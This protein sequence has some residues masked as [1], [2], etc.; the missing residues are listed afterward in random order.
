MTEDIRI[1]FM[2]VPREEASRFARAIIT[3]RLVACVNIVPKMESLYW[4][5]DK[6]LTD[7]ESLLIMKTTRQKYSALQEFVEINHP[8]E[9]PELLAVG[10]EEG[11]PDYLA[12]V[13]VETERSLLD[14]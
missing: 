14:K 10:V 4:W 6:I 13:K 2:S 11:L 3:E 12:W 1:V 5:D 8:Y 9:I 7:E